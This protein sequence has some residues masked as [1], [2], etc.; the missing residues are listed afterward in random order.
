M[1]GK[2]VPQAKFVEAFAEAFELTTAQ[3]RVELAW[4][5]AYGSRLDLADG[6]EL[7]TSARIPTP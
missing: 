1:Y 3:G 4:A 7:S 5:Y 6:L 2:S